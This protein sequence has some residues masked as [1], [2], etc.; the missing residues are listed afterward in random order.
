[1]QFDVDGEVLIGRIAPADVILDGATVSRNHC[2]LRVDDDGRI[3]VRDAGSTGGMFLN[4]ERVADEQ[5][6]GDG[7][8]LRVGLYRLKVMTVTPVDN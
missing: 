4:D 8:E 7:D 5:E 2:W 6:F 1:M 3:T